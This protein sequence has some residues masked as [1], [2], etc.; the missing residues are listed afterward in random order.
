M[1]TP[2]YTP[3]QAAHIADLVNNK[4]TPAHITLERL[5]LGE[6]VRPEQIGLALATL[7]SLSAQVNA[8]SRQAGIEM[9]EVKH[10]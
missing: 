3:K 6:S 8:L 7:R 2:D 1:E 4:I 10:V 9:L 5:A